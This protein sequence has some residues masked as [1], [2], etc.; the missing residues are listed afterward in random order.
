MLLLIWSFRIA[1]INGGGW[2]YKNEITHEVAYPERQN[3]LK[4]YGSHDGSA[5]PRYARR[6]PP[7]GIERERQQERGRGGPGGRPSWP[8][9]FPVRPSG[10]EEGRSGS[11]DGF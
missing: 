6:E 10:E 8:G 3:Y 4:F 1:V 9:R 5:G 7:R 2:R 11:C